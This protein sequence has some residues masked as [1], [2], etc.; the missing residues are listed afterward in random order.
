MSSLII[1]DDQKIKIFLFESNMFLGQTVVL[2][3]NKRKQKKRPGHVFSV[4][5]DK[6]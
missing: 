3:Q 5:D 2:S 4:R 1:G 6:V